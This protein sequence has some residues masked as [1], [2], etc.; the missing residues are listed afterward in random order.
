MIEVKKKM[1]MQEH[2]CAAVAAVAASTN[3]GLRM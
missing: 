2:L 3:L 1:E